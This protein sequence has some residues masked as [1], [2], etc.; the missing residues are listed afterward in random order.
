MNV[1]GIIFI[2]DELTA[3]GL[4]LAGIEVVTVSPGKAAAALAEAR[5]TADVVLLSS[6]IAA[7]LT[8]HALREALLA[9]EPLVAVVP[10]VTGRFPAPDIAGRLKATLGIEVGKP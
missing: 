8:E 5:R 1:A 2:G 4:A 9:T 10:D 7:G 3:T 6:E